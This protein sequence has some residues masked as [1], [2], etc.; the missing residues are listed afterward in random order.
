VDHVDV[1]GHP[2]EIQWAIWL[3]SFGTSSTSGL[4][5][6]PKF[7]L[8]MVMLF[9]LNISYQGLYDLGYSLHNPFGDRRLDVAHEVIGGG[10]AKL[11]AAIARVDGHLPPHLTGA[12]KGAEDKC[13]HGSEG[14]AVTSLELV[15]GG[16]LS[17][18]LRALEVE[19]EEIVSA[20]VF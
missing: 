5:S 16:R 13:S 18:H 6:Q 3:R 20:R 7:W 1:E 2:V 14:A 9:A 4:A 15:D 11:S 12:A 19:V 17:T 8:D 10:I